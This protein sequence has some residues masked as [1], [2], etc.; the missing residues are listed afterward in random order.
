MAVFHHIATTLDTLDRKTH[1]YEDLLEDVRN[2]RV[3]F[4]LKT[5]SE[6]PERRRLESARYLKVPKDF[7]TKKASK[8]IKKLSKFLGRQLSDSN[9]LKLSK[10]FGSEVINAFALGVFIPQEQEDIFKLLFNLT[11]LDSENALASPSQY[12]KYPLESLGLDCN[13]KALLLQLRR[14]RL[15]TLKS[16]D[17]AGIDVNSWLDANRFPEQKY[18][19]EGNEFTLQV[20]DS[21]DFGE[22][23]SFAGNLPTCISFCRKDVKAAVLQNYLGHKH[24]MMI[25]ANGDIVGY[26]RF[27]L[28]QDEYGQP[29]ISLGYARTPMRSTGEINYDHL[30]DY[31]LKLLAYLGLQDLPVYNSNNCPSSKKIGF[32]SYH[33]GIER[34]NPSEFSLNA[35]PLDPY[36]LRALDNWQPKNSW[37]T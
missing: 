21:N 36:E 13:D 7:Q 27:T 26:S 18:Y 30:K 16:I 4:S 10:V 6:S 20:V 17:E 29:M 12:A 15:L 34:D 23:T 2:A 24:I 3:N 35:M 32:S 22:S 25:N 1:F 9:Y 5:I 14:E 11:V 33:F 28:I 8:V 19:I 31:S 37:N